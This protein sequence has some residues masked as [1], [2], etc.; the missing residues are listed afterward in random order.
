MACNYYTITVS[1]LD[2]DDATGNSS[3]FDN[4]LYVDYYDC[5]GDPQT[6]IYDFSGV[7]TN[8]FCANDFPSLTLYYFKNNNI[9]LATYS[10]AD[11]GSSCGASVT[12]T[13]TPT[14][15][16]P[17]PTPTPTNQ[18]TC[19]TIKIANGLDGNPCNETNNGTDQL[20]ITWTDNSGV[21]NTKL[22]SNI[23]YSP[24]YEG[25]NTYFLCLQNLTAPSYKYGQFGTQTLLTC[26]TE[27]IGGDC[28]SD[29]ICSL[30]PTPT[31]TQTKTPTPT[32]TGFTFSIQYRILT[33]IP[34][35]VISLPSNQ[36]DYA[37]RTSN[38]TISFLPNTTVTNNGTIVTTN[39]FVSGKSSLNFTGYNLG[40]RQG[41]GPL[42]NI[43]YTVKKN[44]T[45][46]NT[47]VI[48]NV[49]FTE[50]CN[51]I[52][53][54]T[55]IT[56]LTNGDNVE[57]IYG[58]YVPPTPTTTTTPT[59][60]PT[61]T[62]FA[63]YFSATTCNTYI[64]SNAWAG[65]GGRGIFT[66][67]VDVGEGTGNTD[68]VFNAI[69]I[70]DKWEV[71][72]NG[73]T[74]IDTGFRGSS[75]Y[76][77]ELN[78]LGYPNVSGPASGTTSFNKTSALPSTVTIIITAPLS[79]T[80]WS[81]T[82]ECPD[83]PPTPTPTNTPTT[84]TTLTATPTQTP[85]VT[86]T[87]TPTQSS[88]PANTPS[89]TPTNYPVEYAPN[90]FS[91]DFTKNKLYASTRTTKRITFD[92]NKVGINF[93]NPTNILTVEVT[94]SGFRLS[95]G[96]AESSGEYVLVSD[97]NGV[98]YKT[99][100]PG[101]TIGQSSFITLTGGTT[102]NNVI[103]LLGQNNT[104]TITIP[105]IYFQNGTLSSN[106]IISVGTNSLTFIGANTNQFKI[107][108]NSS[109]NTIQTGT[110]DTVNFSV[111]NNGNLYATSKSF[112]I[113]NK[114]KKGFNLRHGSL[115]G[116]ENGVY[117]RGKTSNKQIEIPTEW[118]WLVN[119]DTIN[120]F[121]TS[122]CGDDIYV[123]SI[124]TGHIIVGGNNCEYSYIVYGERNDIDKMDID[125]TN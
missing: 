114:E 54:L 7:Y 31:P 125:V 89:V 56:T 74:V 12:P 65:S 52:S 90:G 18:G 43:Q 4:T 111:D 119:Y 34:N 124:N 75:T 60:T 69:G 97:S 100:S 59:K 47:G 10:I 23:N 80:A 32:Q 22:W 104:E 21:L 19:W 85:T 61:P 83:I 93:L 62:P 48:N 39:Y 50:I 81:S 30:P 84:T 102:S 16:S 44:G 67:T 96:L 77:S 36:C 64:S 25:Y 122:N 28:Y 3:V 9:Y 70:P 46:A 115:E 40:W 106:R 88:T 57:I 78:A 51:A 17:T 76:N 37:F 120:V 92:Q 94:L 6:V 107:V 8:D 116:P 117:F 98:I 123:D 108:N 63:E 27:E 103:T 1:Q 112:L 42:T 49:G 118:V 5:N 121:L 66:V 33:D 105:E 99:L 82:L 20:Y 87:Q 26:S 73:T 38:E 11:M 95:A 45:V 29:E 58:L 35:N 2:L 53:A 86:S 113:K 55:G 41:N 24:A 72:W 79:G 14:F 91:Y 15:V 13:P 68:L 71:I 101:G 109:G 110:N